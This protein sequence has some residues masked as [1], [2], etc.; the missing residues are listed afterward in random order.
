[1]TLAAPTVAKAGERVPPGRLYLA[2][3]PTFLRLRD[4]A[5]SFDVQFV[6]MP[7]P[8]PTRYLKGDA[9]QKKEH[10]DGIDD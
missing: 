8:T 3:E 4:R 1:M 5:D 10:K 6:L 9:G 2:A 7:Y